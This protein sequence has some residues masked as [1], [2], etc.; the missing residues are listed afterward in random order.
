MELRH[1]Q[2]FVAVAEE[3]HFARAAQRL[4]IAQPPLS[5]QIRQLEQELGVQL[6]ERTTRSVSL[7]S[8]G[9]VFLDEAR[10]A[11]WQVERA[12]TLTR[13]AQRGE[14]GELLVG[15]IT[16]AGYDILPSIL[17]VYH[18]RYPQ[19]DIKP[20][21]MTA[22]EQFEALEERRLHVGFVR[23][24]LTSDDLELEVLRREPVILALPEGHPLATRASIPR[25]ALATEAFI[26]APSGRPST[27]ERQMRLFEDESFRPRVVQE[28]PDILTILGLVAAGI[29]VAV[30]PATARKLRSRAIVYRP[31]VGA[32]MSITALAWRRDEK[33]PALQGF[34]E[35]S[36]QLVARR[37]GEEVTI[38]D[39]EPV[40]AAPLGDLT[41]A[42]GDVVAA[43]TV[44]YRT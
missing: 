18:A 34:L 21:H 28:A 3:L 30:V 1:L 33:C 4:N 31:I 40:D 37:D 11:L 32:P 9:K 20:Y 23:P 27:G 5:K 12:A 44:S 8:A 35:V 24:P 36:R 7:T 16:S 38:S 15:F 26:V 17:Q 43:T 6:L 22:A 10:R 14:V 41:Q 29:G 42:I 25:S 39:G 2:Y 13:Q 19:V